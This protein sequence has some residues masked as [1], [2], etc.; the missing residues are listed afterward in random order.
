MPKLAQETRSHAEVCNRLAELRKMRGLGASEVAQAAGVS[1][2]TIY[3]I[4]AGNYVPNTSVALRICRLLQTNVEEVFL[5]EEDT[6]RT[7]NILKAVLLPGRENASSDFLQLCQVDDQLVAVQPEQGSWTLPLADAVLC[8]PRNGPSNRSSCKVSSY[9]DAADYARRILIAGCDP[10][11]SIVTRFLR[12][13]GV[14]AVVVGRNSSQSLELLRRGLIH[15][16]GM[17]LP[18]S[19]SATA[20]RD[21]ARRLPRREVTVF[22]YAIWEQGLVIAQGNPKSIAG[23]P[24]LRRKDVRIV[25]RETGAGSR[26]LL[27][28]SLKQHGIPASAVRGYDALAS[29]HLKAAAAVG[30]GEADCC[31]ATRAAAR[32][33]ALDFL[34]LVREHY[35]F[36]VQNRHLELPAIQ[37]L[38]ETLGRTALRRE[39][40]EFGGY[41][42]SIAGTRIDDASNSGGKL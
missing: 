39:L 3:A 40:N 36:V 38:I 12:D 41:D 4:E 23:I 2:Q 29:G 27:D 32:L 17:H 18:E 9:R 11:I 42:T 25:N 8:G 20:V 14:E 33:Y 26:I 28:A 35:Y 10:A 1:R 24:D 16:A 37:T 13:A 6:P 31:V 15:V 30:A 34:P 19:E 5:L 7:A 22:S 21:I